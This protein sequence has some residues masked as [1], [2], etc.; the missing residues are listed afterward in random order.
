M[1]VLH[2]IKLHNNHNIQII[3]NGKFNQHSN[4]DILLQILLQLIAGYKND[5]SANFLQNDPALKLLLNKKACIAIDS[6]TF[7][8]TCDTGQH[9]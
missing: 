1:V 4:S 6:V 9:N 3:N 5:S 2:K 8:K 7:F